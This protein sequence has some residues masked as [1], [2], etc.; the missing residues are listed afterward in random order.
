MHAASV[1]GASLSQAMSRF[2]S[3]AFRLRG[4]ANRSEYWRWMLVNFV[5]VTIAQLIV[6]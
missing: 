4:R 3:G 2:V 5:V 1:P 6:P